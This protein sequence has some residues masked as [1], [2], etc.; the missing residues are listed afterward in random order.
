MR[1]VFPDCVLCKTHLEEHSAGKADSVRTPLA[2]MG[3]YVV[4]KVLP[5]SG[6]KA[7]DGVVAIRDIMI[8]PGVATSCVGVWPPG[9]AIV[10]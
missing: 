10:C 8:E 3:V 1:I 9:D 7:A 2:V 5:I 4:R 6:G